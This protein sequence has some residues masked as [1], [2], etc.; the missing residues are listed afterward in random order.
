MKIK[1][2]E[3]SIK[4]ELSRIIEAMPDTDKWEDSFHPSLG[5]LIPLSKAAELS[6]LSQSHLTL[7]IRRGDAWGT[8]VGGR[9]WFTTEKAIRDY[10]ATN[11]KPGPKPKS[12]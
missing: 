7:L 3:C 9:N 11:P 1:F 5:E 2:R 8:K 12:K 4:I 6:G 10:L